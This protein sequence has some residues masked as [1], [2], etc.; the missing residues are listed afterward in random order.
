[1]E[2]KRHL[3]AGL[4]LLSTMQMAWATEGSETATDGNTVIKNYPFVAASQEDLKYDVPQE[5]TVDGKIYKLKD[6]SYEITGHED[7]VTVTKAVQVFDKADYDREITETVDETAL[8]LVA[9]TPVWHETPAATITKEYDRQGA[10]AS[11]LERDGRTYTLQA[12]TVGTKHTELMVP[13]IFQTSNPYSNLFAFGGQT[14]E[15]TDSAAP[16]WDGWEEAVKAELGLNGSSYTLSGGR[17]D[18]D[19]RQ[20]NLWDGSYTRTAIYTGTRETP[21]WTATYQ[22]APEYT[23]EITYVDEK[24]PDGQYAALAVASYTPDTSVIEIVLKVGCGAAVLA[25]AAACIVRLLEKNHKKNKDE[26]SEE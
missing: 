14:I 13:A 15:L 9:T 11:E 3:L 22:S 7:P 12:V 4:L 6:V 5:L 10:V 1:M 16:I 26:E 8:R 23:A 25:L 19:F 24:Y 20:Q 17:W 2:V 18:G 21:V